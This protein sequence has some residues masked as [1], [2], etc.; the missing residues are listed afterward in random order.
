MTSLDIARQGRAAARQIRQQAAAGVLTDRELNR[1]L[2]KIDAGFNQ[3]MGP[4]EGGAAPADLPR[5]PRPL[6]PGV[7]RGFRPELIPGGAL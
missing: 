3:M 2:D 1:L 5:G 7:Q 6:P 4:P